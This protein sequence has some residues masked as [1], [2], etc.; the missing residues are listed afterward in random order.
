MEAPAAGP[1][2]QGGG[3][4]G[5]FPAHAKLLLATIAQASGD[6]KTRLVVCL[7]PFA[8]LVFAVSRVTRR[9]TGRRVRALG[10]ICPRVR[11]RGSGARC[12]L[13]QE[14]VRPV[15]VTHY[16][17]AAAVSLHSDRRHRTLRAESEDQ[18]GCLQTRWITWSGSTRIG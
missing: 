16:S 12:W 5:A 15:G 18:K 2:D 8:S 11:R 14:L 4:D 9:M 6:C 1:R 7:G 10:M 3:S 17:P 13:D